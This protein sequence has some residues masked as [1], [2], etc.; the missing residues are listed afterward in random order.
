MSADKAK[1]EIEGDD[2][3]A[4]AGV[5]PVA[6]SRIGPYRVKALL[7]R[8]G[9]G[10]VHLAWDERLRRHVAIKRIRPKALGVTREQRIRLRREAR[11]AAGLSHPAIVQIHDLLATGDGDYIVMEHVEGE[12][13]TTFL[14]RGALDLALAVRLAREVAEGLAVA[15]DRGVVHRDLKADNVMVTAAGHAKILD[16]GL[17]LSAA[18]DDGELSRPGQPLGTA[19]AMSPELLAGGGVDHRA[20]LFALGVLL[21]EM[22][23]G[24]RPFQGRGA[25]D[26]MRRVQQEQPR[27]PEEIEPRLP[28]PLVDLMARLLA[29]DPQRRPPGAAHVA[30]VLDEIERS[31]EPASGSSGPGNLPAAQA[32]D[33]SDSPTSSYAALPPPAWHRRL[34]L[35][36]ILVAV[37]AVVTVWLW[38]RPDVLPPSGPPRRV[39][40]L[41]PEVTAGE[42]EVSEALHLVASAVLTA[43]LDSL[44]AMPG[45]VPIDPRQIPDAAAAPDAIARATAADDVLSSRVE[46]WP[47]VG[48][49]VS[50][51]RVDGA[52]GEVRWAKSFEA[53]IGNREL[54]LVADGVA[55]QLYRAYPVYAARSAPPTF[56][57]RPEDYADFLELW[58]GFKRDGLASAETAE[59]L[60]AVL[61]GS[62]RFLLAHLLAA[63]VALTRFSSGRDPGLLERAARSIEEARQ[64][65]PD[66]PRPLYRHFRA[67]IMAGELERAEDV[68]RQ[69]ERLAPGDVEILYSSAMLAERRGELQEA[70][71]L[72]LRAVERSPS[73]NSLLR[74]ARVEIRGGKITTAREHLETLLN[75]APAHPWGLAKLAELEL[76][77]GDLERAAALFRRQIE[78]RPRRSLYTNLGLVHYLQRRYEQAITS[79]RQAL[80]LDPHHPM[81]QLN[82]ADAELARGATAAARSRY[83][84]VYEQL[85]ELSR[86]AALDPNEEML[87][88]QCL[89]HLNQVERGLELAGKTLAAHPDDG[90]V[91]FQ[92]AVVYA[93]AGEVDLAL[94]ATRRSVALGIQPRWFSIPIFDPLRHDPDFVAAYERG[95]EG[96]AIT[97]PSSSTPGSP[98]DTARSPATPQ[99]RQV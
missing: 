22:T 56:E 50:L 6:L 18:D 57:V 9:M 61:T 8:G 26:T 77:Y 72:L 73:W 17:V 98:L 14:S 49:R 86:K 38:P 58:Q 65:A 64:L 67:E 36:A 31:L 37:V 7:G 78:Q 41:Q 25:A 21:Y 44:A 81:V 33:L 55:S 84:K 80:A 60:D 11:A 10:E 88:A 34:V 20:D 54:R 75:L 35:A 1:F 91:A 13:V 76:L 83:L 59:R 94:A 42:G 53:P 51:R 68:L 92:A 82:L 19:H 27:P 90:E 47:G 48:C 12:R 16:F 2:S 96:G 69:L 70:R 62:P 29:K 5:E 39:V 89:V 40:V 63:D 24:Q 23:T 93:L 71:R 52:R 97:S 99:T 45:V 32:I 87:M 46:P 3:A 15:H 28:S 95:P 66:D 74:L 43:A 79:Y 30:T 85:E 4:M